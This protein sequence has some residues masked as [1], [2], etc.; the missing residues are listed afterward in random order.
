M[1]HLQLPNILME[2]QEI[3]KNSE[4]FLKMELLQKLAIFKGEI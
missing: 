2:F 4:R 1:Q 3:Y